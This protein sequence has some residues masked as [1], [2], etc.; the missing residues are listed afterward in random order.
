MYAPFYTV[1]VGTVVGHEEFEIFRTWSLLLRRIYAESSLA[2]V[3]G[4]H[5]IRHNDLYKHEVIGSFQL[6]FILLDLPHQ[7]HSGYLITNIGNY[8]S[9]VIF[10]N[11]P[12]IVALVPAAVF[13]IFTL[14]YLLWKCHFY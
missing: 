9:T 11:D 7:Y 3:L 12:Y 1:R 4:I 8:N 2:H 13:L 5:P 14:F 6:Q 10:N